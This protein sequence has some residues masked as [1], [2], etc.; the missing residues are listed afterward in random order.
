[1]HCQAGPGSS[2]DPGPQLTNM[3]KL[4]ISYVC[5][6]ASV[7]C[8]VGALFAG[9]QSTTQL[10]TGVETVTVPTVDAAMGT[11][12][13]Y[14]YATNATAQQINDVSNAYI[15]YFNSQLIASN[16]LAY[17]AANPTGVNV[18]NVINAAT[19]SQCALLNIITLYTTK[20]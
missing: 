13:K 8:V 5:L 3:K 11:W 10:A 16:V 6:F 20:K 19:A 15:V 17:A 7:F 4:S 9:C 12:A 1:M 18:S 14:C 2:D